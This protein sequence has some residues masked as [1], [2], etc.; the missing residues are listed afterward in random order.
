[1]A[2]I[3]ARGVEGGDEAGEGPRF[4]KRAEATRVPESAEDLR[5]VDRTDAGHRP[6]DVVRV[7]STTHHVD[8]LLEVLDL[9]GQREGETRLDGKVVGELAEVELVLPE[10]DRLIGCRQ[11][12]CGVVG[13]PPAVGVPVHETG[14]PGAPE[15]PDQV[16]IGVAGGEQAQRS[17]LVEL[18]IE[19]AVPPGE[20]SSSMASM[21]ATISE[22]RLTRLERSRVARRS[23]SAGPR[24]SSAWSPSACRRGS[25]ARSLESMRSDLVCLE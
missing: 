14:E 20:R 23:G 2:A 3:A 18:A 9:L 24:C 25:V 10:L 1:M 11:H 17:D 7:E 22:R 16:R 12:R 15:A 8:A 5:R 19:R 21:R 13:V 6:Q 4:R